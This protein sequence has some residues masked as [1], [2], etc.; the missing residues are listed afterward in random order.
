MYYTLANGTPSR[1]T[2]AEKIADLFCILRLP[3][4]KRGR[5]VPPT[6]M[7][8]CGGNGGKSTNYPEI[9]K[10]TKVQ[11]ETITKLFSVIPA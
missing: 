11:Y 8:T 6:R 5:D 1:K 4:L 2:I 10:C 9:R 7:H 3:L